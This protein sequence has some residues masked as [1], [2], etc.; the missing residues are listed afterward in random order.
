MVFDRHFAGTRRFIDG[1]G[2]SLNVL[3]A[4]TPDGPVV[5]LVH[6]FPDTHA[7]WLA[8]IA[9][10]ADDFRC[11]AYD[12]RG[13]GKSGVPTSQEGYRLSH[14]V[15]DLVAVVD[16]MSPN[17]P[18]HLVGHDWGSIQAWEAVLMAGS[19]PRLLG[20]ISTYTSISG[21]SRGH[22]AAWARRSSRAD[23]ARRRDLA[24]QLGHSWYLLAFQVPALPELALRRLLRDPQSARRFL[25]SGH[26]APSVA[27]DAVNGLGLYRANLRGGGPHRRSLRTDVPVQLI[28]PLRDPFLTPAVYD[29]LPRYVPQ[30]TRHDIDAGHWV[31]HSHPDEV[32]QLVSDFVR[33]KR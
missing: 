19:D 18:V 23:W 33:A 12:V 15:N 27:R 29:D 11:L 5:V 31:Q 9:R 26:A 10:L 2:V 24:R 20:R 25:G 4:G 30:L 16:A 13:A 17:R 8:T 1:D 7:V 22:F 32:A 28:V 14:L 21:P 3:E 6:G